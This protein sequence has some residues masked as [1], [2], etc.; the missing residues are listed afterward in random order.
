MVH[1]TNGPTEEGIEVEI[2]VGSH[3]AVED[4]ER[5]GEIRRIEIKA[6]TDTGLVHTE[7][8]GKDVTYGKAELCKMLTD[9]AGFAV[10][11]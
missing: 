6:T 4:P 10:V 5:Y 9:A 7:T 2:P 3:I 11:E 1:P 8:N